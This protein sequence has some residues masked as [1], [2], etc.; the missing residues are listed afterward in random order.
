MT[1]FALAGVLRLIRGG[2]GRVLP[3]L[4]HRPPTIAADYPQVIV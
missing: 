4:G 1:T 3:C 2:W